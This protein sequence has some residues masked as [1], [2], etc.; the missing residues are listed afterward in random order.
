MMTNHL[1]DENGWKTFL[2]HVWG[3]LYVVCYIV[4]QWAEISWAVLEL[5][6]ASL[7]RRP[8]ANWVSV[9]VAKGSLC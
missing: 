3:S 2:C 4:G 5:V 6:C 8:T 7:K 9:V 1:P